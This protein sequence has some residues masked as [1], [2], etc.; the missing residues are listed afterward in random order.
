MK[1]FYFLITCLIITG[2]AEYRFNRLI[3]LHPELISENYI[4]IKD[5]IIENDTFIIKERIDSFIIKSDTVIITDRYVIEKNNESFIIRYL[6]DTIIK[7]DTVYFE[8][9]IKTVSVKNNKSNIA[10]FI[11]LF[12]FSAVIL[13]ALLVAVKELM[14]T[15]KS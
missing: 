9:K 1:Y 14:K 8:S 11:F 4:F 5:T 13:L 2:C 6:T 12:V 7:K 10:I 15:F 3:K